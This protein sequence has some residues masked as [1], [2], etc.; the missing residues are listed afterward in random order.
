MKAR[1]TALLALAACLVVLAPAAAWAQDAEAYGGFAYVRFDPGPLEIRP[2]GFAFEGTTYIRENLGVTGEFMWARDSQ[3]VAGVADAHVDLLL[4][5]GGVRYRFPMDSA[6]TPSVRAVAGLGRTSVGA[7]VFDFCEGISDN[8]FALALG[9]AADVAVNEDIAIRV[10][11]DIVI[12]E[13]ED[14][15]YRFTAGAVFSF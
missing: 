7:C 5:M 11:P 6:V 15:I 3:D 1:K 8:T 9:G 4:A 14:T 12:L 10:Q 13:F 2:I